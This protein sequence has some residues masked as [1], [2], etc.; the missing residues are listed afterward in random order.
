MNGTNFHILYETHAKSVH[1]F[2]HYLTGS[3]EEADEITAETFFR[4]WTSTGPIRQAS[5]RSYL[6][7]IARNLAVDGFRRR[8]REV[9]LDAEWPSHEASP[10]QKFELETAMA[11]MSRL[12]PEYSEPLTMSALGGLS[13]DEIAAALGLPLS[14]VKIR[15]YRARVQLAGELNRKRSERT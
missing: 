11:A 14:T 4:A 9:E 7:T 8:R 6:I 3:R 15:I 13:Y 12:P 10:D 1:R 5:A 2:V